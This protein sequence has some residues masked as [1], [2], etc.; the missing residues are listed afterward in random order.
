MKSSNLKY[1][2]SIIGILTALIIFFVQ[3]PS[4]IWSYL[5]VLSP[6]A[7]AAL[8]YIII[9]AASRF[10]RKYQALIHAKES[11]NLVTAVSIKST[12]RVE[13][14]NEQGDLHY[15]RYFFYELIKDGVTINKTRKDLVSSEVKINNF[16]PSA[17]VISSIPNNIS[18]K[19]CEV[20][21]DTAIRSE[22]KHYDYY[23]RYKINPALRNKDDCLE[24]G[25]SAKIAECEPKAFSDKGALFF[26]HHEALP[27]D[28]HYSLTAPRG[29]SIKIMDSWIEDNSGRKH[30]ISGSNSPNIN[31][32]GQIL[33][34]HPTYRKQATFICKYKMVPA[35]VNWIDTPSNKFE[36]FDSQDINEEN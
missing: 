4:G 25:Y 9:K 28:V 14:L 5:F 11:Y 33:S 1:S 21:S 15:E 27:L 16:P 31:E 30:E 17:N 19:P 3:E 7:I 2:L 29:Y 18:L 10:K 20:Y 23:W 35:S 8:F 34:W 6:L 32:S 24:Y 36:H 26:F 12:Y 22:R 13:I